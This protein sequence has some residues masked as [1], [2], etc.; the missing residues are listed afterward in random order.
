[1]SDNINETN[2]VPEDC[3]HDCSTCGADCASR[4]EGPESF[5]KSLRP[6]ARVDKVIAVVSGKGGFTINVNLK[7]FKCKLLI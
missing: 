5:L 4:Q 3:T 1:M 7:N 6:G 2:A